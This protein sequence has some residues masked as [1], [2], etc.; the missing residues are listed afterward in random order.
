MSGGVADGATSDSPSDEA[1]ERDERASDATAAAIGPERTNGGL[2]D[3]IDRSPGRTSVWI[4]VT[5]A[6]VCALVLP[7]MLA[8]A[9]GL[10]GTTLV[11]AGIVFRSRRTVGY[12]TLVLLATVTLS[13]V[14]GGTPARV[15]LSTSLA[16]L[17]WDTGRYG[18][19]VGE[20]LGRDA[21]T[22]R[23]ELAHA[24][25]IASVSAAAGAVGYATFLFVD[26]G[27][28]GVAIVTLTVGVLVL[29]TVLR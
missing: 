4:A 7:S 25:A 10:A 26:G 22:T 29:V 9:V 1:V 11:A 6:A 15:V 20:Q 16:L 12:G 28:S 3:P 24:T 19:T 17:A 23:L 27:E 21:A 2:V 5:S 8:V 13:G 18:I 14:E